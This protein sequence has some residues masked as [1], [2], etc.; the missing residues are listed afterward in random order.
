MLTSAIIRTEAALNRYCLK[1]W[2]Q[3]PTFCETI[4]HIENTTIELCYLKSPSDDDYK[5]YYLLYM[6]AATAKE[7]TGDLTTIR[8]K[9]Y[10]NVRTGKA[11]LLNV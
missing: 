4:A 7:A 10:E 11:H 5:A 2:G 3:L 9:F 6:E 8:E 1:R